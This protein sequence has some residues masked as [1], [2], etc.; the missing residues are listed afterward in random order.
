MFEFRL[1]FIFVRVEMRSFE[2]KYRFCNSWNSKTIESQILM[3]EL[4]NSEMEERFVVYFDLVAT[5]NVVIS[6]QINLAKL[7]KR[8]IEIKFQS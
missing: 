8:F 7:V 2:Q 6:I 3:I 1:Q 5:G 4:S